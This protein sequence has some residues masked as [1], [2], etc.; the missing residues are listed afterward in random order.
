MVRIR[1]SR[2]FGPEPPSL[3]TGFLVSAL[4][5]A[6]ITAV[7]YPLRNVSPPA[8]DG[9]AYLLAVL[10]VATIWGFWL[11]VAT[12]LVSGAA[13][14]YF[15]LPPTG[16]FTISDSR[17]WVALATFLAAAVV[18]SAVAELARSRAGEAEQRRREA[19]L[20]AELSR[21]LLGG[22]IVEATLGAASRRLADALGLRSAAIELAPL[23]RRDSGLAFELWSDGGHIGALVVPSDIT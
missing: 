21:L 4:A 16:Q 7:I 9:V 3:L 15:H 8:S 2:V 11:G 18:A 19:D 22:P 12:S 1:A 10:L 23:P 20:A 6:A 5:V 14:N 13:F 17:H